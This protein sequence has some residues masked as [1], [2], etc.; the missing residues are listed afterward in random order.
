MV[1]SRIFIYFC[2]TA[3]IFISCQQKT[4]R[5]VSNERHDSSLVKLKEFNLRKLEGLKQYG[6]GDNSDLSIDFYFHTDD[7]MKAQ[8]LANDLNNK[9][10][11]A[12]P[13]HRS[14]NNK[15]IWVLSAN[16]SRVKMDIVSLTAWTDSICR[17]GFH[18]D[19]EFSGWNPVTE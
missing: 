12:N 3:V 6:V 17:I 18:H 19:C 7:S 8:H 9:N 13:V 14:A 15:S 2:L 16:S 1:S 10:Y 11:H 4:D 5:F